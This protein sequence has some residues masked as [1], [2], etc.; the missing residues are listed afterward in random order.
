MKSKA[1]N[2]CTMGLFTIY[3]F[4]LIWIILFKL[5]LDFSQLDYLRSIN[6]IPLSNSTITNGRIDVKEIIYNV[7]VFIPVG[8][9]ITMLKPEWALGKKIIP[10][11]LI[12][13]SFEVLQFILAIG[14]SDITDLMGNTLGGI[15]GIGIFYILKKI[16]KTQTVK[17][18]NILALIST[19]IIVILLT[20]LIVINV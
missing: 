17:F 16:F 12:S 2:S 18:L 19:I 3:L 9:Y 11:F 5:T 15:I 20:L 8:I 10:C 14:A 7:L 6:L 1:S 4:I 13:L